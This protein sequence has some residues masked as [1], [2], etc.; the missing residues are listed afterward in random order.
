MNPPYQLKSEGDMLYVKFIN[1]VI[2]ISNKS[3]IISPT[4]AFVSKSKTTKKLRD[5]I[6]KYKPNLEILSEKPFDAAI[7]STLCISLFDMINIQE[8]IIVNNKKFKTQ[9]DII[10]NDNQYLKDFYDK[11]KLYFIN[12]DSLYDKCVANPKNAQYFDPT[13]KV[14]I[15]KNW[16]DKNT[17]FTTLPY[18]IASFMGSVGYEQYSDKLWNGPARILIPFK[19][20]NKSKNCCNTLLDQNS[21]RKKLKDFFNMI[22]ALGEANYIRFVDRYKY[23]PWLDFSKSYTNEELFEIIGMKYNK[24]EINKI[25]KADS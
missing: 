5:N 2:E 8:N 24:E 1:K 20:E 15:I 16:K 17:W 9:E 7:K 13:G 19:S 25:L 3:I 18:C 6:N 23:Y 10:L 4:P 14:K 22:M 11:L 12:N 21:K